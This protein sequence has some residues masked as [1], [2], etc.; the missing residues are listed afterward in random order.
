MILW[1]LLYPFDFQPRPFSSFLAERKVSEI[2]KINL[3]L[4]VLL[5]MPLGL[6]AGWAWKVMFPRRWALL[7]LLVASDAAVLSLI[8][9][10]LQMWLPERS[11]A[12]FE[13]TAAA[14]PMLGRT[15]SLIDLIANITGGTIAGF[16]G[17]AF[18]AQLTGLWHRLGDWLAQ[19]PCGRRAFAVLVIV[20]L[21]RAAP[22]DASLETYYLR[23]KFNYETVPAGGPFSKTRQWLTG[24]GPRQAP[25]SAREAA[26]IELRRAA[27]NL[28]LFLALAIALTQAMRE[29]RTMDHRTGTGAGMALALTLLLVLA[30][31]A[32]QL[33]IR[34]RMMDATDPVA[35]AIG[36]AAGVIIG[37][38]MGPV[39]TAARRRS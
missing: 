15:S 39:A 32:L 35:G 4:N 29:K 12:L 31:E 21:A 8:G 2:H 27:I 13:S 11:G 18:T 24:D 20:L 37:L 10:Y 14:S 1:L 30:T 33:P 36:G 3:V 5:F 17:I 38:M 28:A 22:F 26:F 9:E 19:H 23:T 7:V 34:S 16:L 25:A 6:F